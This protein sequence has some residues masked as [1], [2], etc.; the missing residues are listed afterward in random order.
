MDSLPKHV[1]SGYYIITDNFF[2]CSQLL[3]SLREKEIAATGTVRLNRAE[4]ATLNPVK[5]M[6]K[7]KG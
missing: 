3:R 1:R 6:E 5:K 7:L 2:T 4:N